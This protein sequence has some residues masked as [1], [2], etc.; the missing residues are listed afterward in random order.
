[1][2]ISNRRKRRSYTVDQITI[3]M[4]KCLENN[5][6]LKYIFFGGKGGVG[7]DRYGRGGSPVG[8]EAGEED[9]IGLD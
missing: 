9:I 1:L 5:P 3:G 4:K 7:I 2:E 8:G 6:K